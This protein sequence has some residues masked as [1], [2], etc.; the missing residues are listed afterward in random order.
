MR[1]KWA[2]NRAEDETTDSHHSE[3]V[4]PSLKEPSEKGDKPDVVEEVEKQDNNN[5]EGILEQMKSE[6]K[7][8]SQIRSRRLDNNR[9][10]G[11]SSEYRVRESGRGDQEFWAYESEK[12][13][14]A[15]AEGEGDKALPNMLVRCVNE[16]SEYEG[17]SRQ[18]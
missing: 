16:F 17:R 2:L 3:S 6:I 9:G 10:R 14:E 4:S 15:D 5:M 8:K 1:S 7:M 11:R 13:S 18:E 12:D